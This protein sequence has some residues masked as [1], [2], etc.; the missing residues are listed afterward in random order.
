[1]NYEQWHEHTTMLQNRYGYTGKPEKGRLAETSVYEFVNDWLPPQLTWQIMSYLI[2]PH[3]PKQVIADHYNGIGQRHFVFGGVNG[4]EDRYAAQVGLARLGIRNDLVGHLRWRWLPRKGHFRIVTNT[5][6]TR[7]VEGNSRECILTPEN[8]MWRYGKLKTNKVLRFLQD[9]YN[10]TAGR[11][12][13]TNKNG[14]RV[15]KCK[16]LIALQEANVKGRTEL[17]KNYQKLERLTPDEQRALFNAIINNHTGHVIRPLNI[18]RSAH[19][20][21]MVNAL[22]KL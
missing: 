7:Y 11:D 18:Q 21:V 16:V 20:A 1:M 8:R 12:Y 3:A 4:D 14:K 10:H 6:G 9:A 5:S 2:E 15:L 13:V 19:A 22:M 17:H